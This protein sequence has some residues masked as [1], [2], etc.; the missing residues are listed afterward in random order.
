MKLYSIKNS[1]ANTKRFHLPANMLYV[2]GDNPCYKVR[3]KD[4]KCYISSADAK[5]ADGMISRRSTRKRY[6]SINCI[7]PEYNYA[8]VRIVTLSKMKEQALELT[9]YKE[10]I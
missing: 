6:V 9:L 10:K 8:Q 1:T 3:M 5:D 2:F 4:G 7:P